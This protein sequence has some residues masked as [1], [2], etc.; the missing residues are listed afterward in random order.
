VQHRV[1]CCWLRGKAA[2]FNNCDFKR[3]E[4]GGTESAVCNKG[5]AFDLDGQVVGALSRRTQV[6]SAAVWLRHRRRQQHPFW[7]EIRMPSKNAKTIITL[8]QASAPRLRGVVSPQQCGSHG[9]AW[10]CH[11]SNN[12]DVFLPFSSCYHAA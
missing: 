8:V 12:D 7:I 4:G 3:S 10:K 5:R 2:A 6:D 1:V 11:C 9:K